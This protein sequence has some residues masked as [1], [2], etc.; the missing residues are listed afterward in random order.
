MD[1]RVANMGSHMTCTAQS[2]TTRSRIWC[3]FWVLL[4]FV[5]GCAVNPVTGQREITLVSTEREIAI[6]REQY[7]P[8]QQMQGGAYTT[9]PE[10]TAYVNRVGQKVAR[11][12]GV[13]LPYEFVVLNHSVPNAWA[14]PGGKI[15]INRGLLTELKNEAELAAV[16]GHEVAHA[17]ARHGA[18]RIERGLLAQGVLLGTVVLGAGSEYGGEMLQGAQLAAG[19]LN[20]K[21]SRDAEREADFYGTRFM[22]Q[23]GY[24]PHAAVTLQETFVR[25]SGEKRTDFIQ[26]LFASHPPSTERV[27]N[28][29]QLVAQLRNEGFT[30]GVFGG[31][32][33]DTALSQVRKAGPAFEHFDEAQ[34]AYAKENYAAA[35]TSVNKALDVTSGEAVFHGLRGAIRYQQKRY[36]DAV[37]NFD[38]AVALDDGYFVYYL[39]RG[40]SHMQAGNRSRAKTDLDLSVRLLPTSTA[41]NA[42]GRL[43][44]QEG[45]A[46]AAKRYY[47]QAGQG[48]GAAGTAARASLVRLEVPSQPGKYVDAQVG[49]DERGQVIVQVV[50]RAPVALHNVVVQVEFVDGQGVSTQ[51]VRMAAMAPGERRLAALGSRAQQ[52]SQFRAYA[53]AASV[54]DA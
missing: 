33:Y 8:S 30:D 29:R 53:V 49:R 19:L 10:L 20:Q 48:Q 38:R 2:G 45:D 21:Y 27:S 50:N 26:G 5:T 35:L 14:L 40:L 24:D 22:A 34:A 9:D 1:S 6:G 4:V 51:S 16:L 46:E 25:L 41:Y 23:A 11:H 42:L 31:P 17:A 54:P 15:A 44:E 18:K 12:S 47:A 7:G 39:Q 32:A 13:D 52:A 43:A 36:D 37:T 3:V 28:N